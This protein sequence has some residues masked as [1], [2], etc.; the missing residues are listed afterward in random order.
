MRTFSTALLAVIVV[1]AC[2]SGH[3]TTAPSVV[4]RTAQTSAGQILACGDVIV[5]DVVLEND[6]TCPGNGLTV[7]GTDINI[8]LN[9]H[10]IAGAGVGQ[11]I[12]VNASQGV[13]IFGG[14]V[15]GFLRGI[16]V[17][18]STGL[19]IRDNE[20]TENGTAVLVQAS[21]GNIIRGN[22]AR[23]NSLRAF[24]LRPDLSGAVVSTNNDIV[25]NVLIDNPTGIYLIRQPGNAI[26]AN[27]ISGSSVAAIDLDP[28]PLGASGTRIMGNLLMASG[29]GIRFG[30]G[31][32]DNTIHG[33]RIL[34]NS[35]GFQGA[36]AGN[37][38]QGN[39]LVANASDFCP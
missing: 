19:V 34:E 36:S 1:G 22:V 3:D 2:T 7:T 39:S 25:E 20:F 31:W 18:V 5:S 6:L 35:C 17:N 30:A 29:A 33:N 32:T 28:A 24:M 26:T 12:T 38:L 13:S 21:S 9:G 15:R 37:A 10:T 4:P 11:G 8:D 23:Q 14:S 27:R 16:L